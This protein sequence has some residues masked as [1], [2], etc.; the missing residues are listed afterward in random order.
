MRKSILTI[1]FVLI[2]SQGFGQTY[3]KNLW[4][5]SVGDLTNTTD[6]S[7][8]LD[9]SFFATRWSTY[10]YNLTAAM[11]QRG[12]S[13]DDFASLAACI[14]TAAADTALVIVASRQ[15]ITASARDTLPT[16]TAMYVRQGGRI[17]VT[18]K[19][20]IEGAFFAGPYQVFE[21]NLDSVEFA[22]GSIDFVLPQWFGAKTSTASDS[23]DSYSAIQ[24]AI[25]VAE[26]SMSSGKHDV[27]VILQNGIYHVSDT[28]IITDHGI[29]IRFE[30]A[31]LKPY[32][33]FA[34][35]LVAIKGSQSTRTAKIPENWHRAR[36]DIDGLYIDGL[37]KA[38]GLYVQDV[39]QGL[40]SNVHIERSSGYAVKL[41]QHKESVWVNLNIQ[42]SDAGTDSAL[43]WIGDETG[44][45]DGSNAL[46]FIAPKITYCGGRYVY[47]G[48]TSSIKP[49]LIYFIAP[50]FH[51][52][53]TD[54]AN[55][56]ANVSIDSTGNENVV[57]IENGENIHF[58]FGLI[59]M[60]VAPKGEIIKLGSSGN[61]PT[62]VSFWRTKISS[63]A[64][65]VTGIDVTSSGRITLN[66]VHFV[67]QG[68]GAKA[69]TTPQVWRLENNN[70]FVI[71]FDGNVTTDQPGLV[72]ANTSNQSAASSIS[73]IKDSTSIV[74]DVEKA[75]EPR[76]ELYSSKG[77]RGTITTGASDSRVHFQDAQYWQFDSTLIANLGLGIGTAAFGGG[78]K[79]IAL[80]N[81]GVEP[82]NTADHAFIFVR[83]VTAGQ[84]SVAVRNETTGKG[85]IIHDANT[86]AVSA[87]TGSV[88][89]NSGSANPLTIVGWAPIFH[90]AIGDTIWVPYVLKPD[91]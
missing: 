47:V 18:R 78:Q 43:L 73:E 82:N 20:T 54:P 81:D 36:V 42:T 35:P 30:D 66:D 44:S 60:P 39:M 12:Y 16:T 59:R 79:V 31:V 76:L 71:T 24:K 55:Q 88:T 3:L 17:N 67:L 50:Q 34:G 25:D 51:H 5:K 13:A 7:T 38:R 64:D 14:D 11:K 83:D 37:N 26:S 6:L 61:T 57:W 46:T 41:N 69:F 63:D 48:N 87:S 65:S 19:F 53:D 8:V 85:F 32:E 9:S 49:R 80:K 86:G 21:G 15:T 45:Q 27:S 22:P 90:P 10:V 89:I 91:P 1:L 84:A 52:L 56:N 4:S 68:S 33:S 74:L 40:F 75:T 58:S 23:T 77:Y 70:P 28:L 72:V 2:A 29:K 62:S